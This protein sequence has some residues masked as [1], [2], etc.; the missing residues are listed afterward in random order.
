MEIR[1]AMNDNTRNAVRKYSEMIL[2]KKYFMLLAILATTMAMTVGKAF[3]A[4]D[5]SGAG[6][7]ANDP[8]AKAT[9]GLN[10]AWTI[11][12][13]CLVWFMQLG[14]A[15]LG[16]GALRSKAQTNYWSKSYI[17]FSIGVVIFALIGYALMFGGS[18]A[19]F[20]GY[21]D[22]KGNLIPIPGLDG[23]N[24]WVGWSGFGLAGDAY[25]VVTIT[26]FFFEAV[27]AATSVTIVAGMVAE[28][29]KFQAYLLYTILINILIYPIYGH[30]VW[31]NGWLATLPFGVGARDFSGSGVVHAVGG[32]TGLAG[33]WL[34]GPRIGKYNK[35]GTANSFPAH[36]IPYLYAGTFILFFGWFGF[37]PA[38]TLAATDYRISIIAVN[39]YLAGG[40]AATINAYLTFIIRKKSDA[41]A[42]A[43]GALGGLVAITAPCAYVTPLGSIVI[44]LIAGP[45]V[46]YG[47]RF[48]ER[49]LKIDD[50]VG[51]WGVH[52][53]NGL[54]GLL[55]VGLFSDGSYGNVRGIFYGS[56]GAGQ[57]V[58][59]LISM[60]VV[61]PFAFGMGLVVFGAIKATIGIRV[62][63]E[64]ELA[65][66]DFHEHDYVAYPETH[67][68]DIPT[69]DELEE[70]HKHN[71]EM[72]PNVS[73]SKIA[74][75]IGGSHSDK[76]KESK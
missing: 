61:A 37:N 55:A 44:G 20:P 73:N 12:M 42:I 49:T 52:G 23:G 72:P 71:V 68:F 59:Q 15:F 13:A 51:A 36:N 60:V 22:A 26:H 29:L 30:W 28:R 39:T 41:M 56:A 40:A 9:L 32:F 58:A 48:V 43:N 47:N 1:I 7:F 69:G 8:V 31:G 17:D 35:D 11:I 18:G 25:D 14:F 74:P 16:A 75:I 66:L 4:G 53:A 76:E 45:L 50:A 65:G 64:V 21:T 6:I 33:A 63:P 19:T 27:F 67:I 10:M 2:Q 57:L 24:Q 70:R 62:E 38:S 46:I 34:L 5:P 54:F 3:A